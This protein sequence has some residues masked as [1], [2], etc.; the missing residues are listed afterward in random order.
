MKKIALILLFISSFISS[1][2][3]YAQ[4]TDQLVNG[5]IK[6][7]TLEDININLFLV[8][9][10]GNDFNLEITPETEIGIETQSGERWVGNISENQDYVFNLLEE[11]QHSLEPMTAKYSGNKI[12]SIVSYESSNIKNNLGYLAGSFIFLAILFFGYIFI[13]NN[14]LKILSSKK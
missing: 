1:Q 7:V 14:K 3:L 11:A 9:N 2:T 10:F 4:D 8:D 6:D 13:I 12:T 5:F